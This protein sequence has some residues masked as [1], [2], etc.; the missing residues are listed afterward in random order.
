[1]AELE[2]LIKLKLEKDILCSFNKDYQSFETKID[3]DSF[4]SLVKNMIKEELENYR[5]PFEINETR[6]LS[7]DK[8]TCCARSMGKRY[9]EKRCSYKCKKNTDYCNMHHN[10]IEKRG[11]L[12]FGRYDEKRPTIN[13]HGNKIPWRD[14]TFKDEMKILIDYQNMML[15]KNIAK[16][17]N[18]VK[19]V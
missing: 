15:S 11:F 2:Q 17:Q 7:D 13:E 10:M 8:N 6:E 3:K 4:D 16:N 14:N 18:W 19:K 1:M 12:L 5:F 9:T